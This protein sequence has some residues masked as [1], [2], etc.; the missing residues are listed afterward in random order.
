MSTP[1]INIQQELDSTL[2]DLE[3]IINSID[4]IDDINDLSGL[5]Q[6]IQSYDKNIKTIN[7]TIQK[8]SLV[9]DNINVVLN[10]F[11]TKKNNKSNNMYD[12]KK[13]TNTN[14]PK[15]N[16]IGNIIYKNVTNND[17]FN[18]CKFAKFAVINISNKDINLIQNTPIYY[19]TETKQYCIKLN[20]N[21]IMGNISNISPD[22]K[23]KLHKC[24]YPSCNNKYYNKECKYFHNNENR[25]FADYSWKHITKDKLGKPKYKNNILDFKKYDLDNTRFIGSLETL[26][27]DL[28]FSSVN[29]K[30]LR[31]KQLMHDILLY[32]ILSEYL[33]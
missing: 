31:N 27:D 13:I 5:Y 2:K 19:I 10:N 14:H 21:L 16:A 8:I 22:D 33:N 3:N 12:N 11:I 17:T 30:N 25:N 32:L 15:C 24:K 4:D 29:E 1:L 20:N 18:S 9:K 6:K 23:T 26:I 28:P 7:K